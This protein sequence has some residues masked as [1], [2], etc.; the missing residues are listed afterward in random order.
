MV[1]GLGA[2]AGGEAVAAQDGFDGVAEERTGGGAVA[3]EAGIRGHRFLGGRGGGGRWVH[4]GSD[5]TLYM[6]SS[7]IDINIRKYQLKRDKQSY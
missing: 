1:C 3:N 7:S 4:S 5:A 2:Q 6:S